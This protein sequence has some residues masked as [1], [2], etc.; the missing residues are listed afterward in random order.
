MDHNFRPFTLDDTVAA[1]KCAK[2]STALGPDGL[3][4]LHLKHLGPIALGYLTELFNL[5]VANSDLPAIWKNALVL[6]VLKPNKSPTESVSYRPIL[7]LCPASKILER[8]LLPY[9]NEHLDLDDSQHG[10][11]AGRSPTSALLPLV[12]SVADGFNERKPAKRTIAVSI[13]LSKAFDSVNHDKLLKKL[14][15]TTLPHNIV[16]WLAAF[17][18]GREQCVIYNGHKS[19]N[20]HVHLGVPQ[21]AVLSPTLFNFFVANFPELQCSKTS[22][23]DDFT[24]FT[25]DS[26]IAAAE[27]RINADLLLIS[28]W[29]KEIGLDIAPSK[30]S[31]TLFTS[32]THEHNYHPQVTLPEPVDLGGVFGTVVFDRVLP[33]VQQP[34]LL[35][36][37]LDT[38]FTFSPHAR[39]IAKGCSERHKLVKALAG[40]SWGQDS[41]TLLMTYKALIRSKLDYAA[42]VWAPNVKPTPLRRLQSIQNAGLRLATG[43]IKMSSPDHLHSEAQMLMVDEHIYLL[44]AQYLASALRESHPAFDIVTRPSGSRSMKETLRRSIM[45]LLLI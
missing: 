19:P 4:A 39:E 38:H 45:M 27:A 42:P 36:V 33:L 1:I 43:T 14:I 10:F 13:D 24:I 9:L 20:K 30:S 17:I 41:R 37:R 25:S 22:F 7:L 26:D 32:D 21:G 6:P 29:A 15:N 8:L 40:T 3:A 16:R 44:A 34:K 5:S 23:A 2:H 18:K 35:G 12:T 28:E 11:R 31:V